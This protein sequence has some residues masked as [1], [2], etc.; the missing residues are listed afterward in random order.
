MWKMP[1]HFS[2]AT[3][4]PR[5]RAARPWNTLGRM[6]PDADADRLARADAASLTSPTARHDMRDGGP[7]GVWRRRVVRPLLG[8]LRQGLTPARLAAS[9]AVGVVVSVFPVLGT[10]TALCTAIA[11]L[12]RLNLVAMQAA[13]YAAFP[14]Q[15]LLLVPFLRLGERALGAPR[16]PL[17]ATAIVAAFERGLGHALRTLSTALGHAVVGWAVV[18]VPAA[19]L[20]YVL[21]RPLAGRVAA[22]LAAGRGAEG[23]RG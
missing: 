22:R 15:V 16:A 7:R 19:L 18:A 4:A 8:V 5:W 23:G 13:N 9:V 2:D 1:M 21:L 12:A 20:L 11:L 14:L 17:G 10:T 6:A 3:L